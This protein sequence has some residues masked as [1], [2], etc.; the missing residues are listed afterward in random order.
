MRISDR[1]K[2]V[3]WTLFMGMALAF[4]AY[5]L[6]FFTYVASAIAFSGSTG[7]DHARFFDGLAPAGTALALAVAFAW[8]VCLVNAIVTAQGW[9]FKTIALAAVLGGAVAAA[10]PASVR[11]FLGAGL[12]LMSGLLSRGTQG[13]QRE[14]ASDEAQALAYVAANPAVLAAAGGTPSLSLALRTMTRDG[15]TTRYDVSV[16]GERTVYAIVSV[17]RAGGKQKLSLA[18]VTPL[19]IGQRESGK[20]VCAG[21]TIKAGE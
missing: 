10:N 9:W 6:C 14:E 8:S 16:A 19:W 3:A 20:D 5:G 7:A 11:P 21:P 17:E 12:T 1:A 18:C 2:R 15:V 4:A 13:R